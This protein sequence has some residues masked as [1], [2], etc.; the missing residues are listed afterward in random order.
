MSVGG[1]VPRG[2]QLSHIL[3]V[4]LSKQFPVRRIQGALEKIHRVSGAG[5]SLGL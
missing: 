1:K 5:I 3:E 4:M 2:V